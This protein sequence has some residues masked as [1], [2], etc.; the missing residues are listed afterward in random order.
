MKKIINVIGITCI[1]MLTSCDMFKPS[2]EV[3]YA[4]TDINVVP[5]DSD[6]IL[7]NQ[8]VLIKDNRIFKILPSANHLKFHAKKV[9]DGNGQYM[10]P[11]LADMHSHLRMNPQAMFNQYVAN[12][13][14]TIRNMSLSDGKFDHLSI[15][16]KVRSGEMLGPRYL[17]SGPQLKEEKLP[18]LASA[19]KMMDFYTSEGFDVVKIHSDLPEDIYNLVL[20]RAEQANMMV[21]GHTQHKMPL[22]ETLRMDSIEHVEELLY[23]SM[24][25]DHVTDVDAEIFFRDHHKKLQDFSDVNFRKNM[26]KQF[27]DTHTSIVSTLTIFDTILEWLDDKRFEQL[28]SREANKYLP[29]SIKKQY[30]N[31]ERNP[32]RDPNWPFD[33]E[34]ISS[35]NDLM[36]KLVGEFHQQGV[37]FILGVD[38]FGTVVPGFSIHKELELLV[39]SGLTPYQALQTG[40]I[41]VAKYLSEEDERGTISEGKRADFIIIANNPLD[42]IS[43]TKQVT[44]VFTHNRWL[45]EVKLKEMLLEAVEL[46]KQ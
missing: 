1:F 13:V 22:S 40:T 23:I 2:I 39:A 45:D 34:S 6:I 19:Q 46:N 38:A 43:H 32:Y 21:T 30:L 5:M 3:D 29:N 17:I 37:N 36:K 41:N 7:N 28:Q 15:R 25:E 24:H 18:D 20:Q 4:I 9:I 27:A 16:K 35:N 44:S 11:G 8:T 26:A 12:G 10:L 14:T 31:N 33:T 42:N